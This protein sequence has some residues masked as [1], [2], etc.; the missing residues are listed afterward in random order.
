[1]KPFLTILSLFFFCGSLFSQNEA[2]ARQYFQDGN[3]K[4]AVVYYQKLH[5]ENPANLSNLQGLVTCYQQLETY[6]EAEKLLLNLINSPYYTP[7]LLVEI[8]YNYFLQGKQAEANGYFEK[9]LQVVIENP[10]MAYSIGAHLKQK[11]VLNYAIKVYKKAMELNPGLNFNYDLALIYGEQGDIENMYNT[12]LDLIAFKDSYRPNVQRNL[13]MFISEEPTAEN[14]LLLKKILLKKSQTEPNP[15]WNEMLS[16]LFIQQKQFNNA[17]VQEKAIL[18][19][20]D[21]QSVDRMVDLGYEAKQ[22]GDFK[23]AKEIFAF[24]N[25]NFK[26]RA[27]NLLAAENLLEMEVK[28]AAPEMYFKIAENFEKALKEF[29]SNTE[30]LNLQISYANFLA[31]QQNNPQKA[32]ALLNNALQLPVSKYDEANIKMAMADILVFDEKHNQAILYYAQ[33]QKMVKND[34][35]SQTARFK[36]AQTSFYK[37]DFKWA[38][39]QLKILKSSTSQLIANDALQLKLLIS[40]NSL[41]DSTHAALKLYAKAHLLGYQNKTPEAIAILDTLLAKHRS[42]SIEDEA[43]LMQAKLFEKQKQFEKAAE[44]YQKIISFFPWDVLID[45]A[46]FHLAELYSN[47]LAQPDKAKELYERI[48]FNHADSIFFV[49]ARKKFRKLRGDAIN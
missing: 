24:L 42:E 13:G 16:W 11:S 5:N 8:G 49:E 19:R 47:Q 18:K 46:L 1:M 6:E 14:N 12:Y 27:L 10:A 2:L 37:G 39:D 30:T 48:I 36:E 31:F 9:A 38:E 29:G 22:A 20:T 25:E 21:N 32:L 45:D 41:Q 28:E 7:V 43:L 34:V 35:L 40:D 33:I 17:F 3:F 15:L 4:K 23:I 44:N 26:D